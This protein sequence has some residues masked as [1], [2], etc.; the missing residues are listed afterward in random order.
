MAED[1]INTPSHYH[2]GGIDVITIL[3]K[4]FG[5]EAS[6]GF[7]LGN[8]LKYILRYPDKG[9]VSS[10]EKARFYL[11]ALIN[12]VKGKEYVQKTE[13]FKEEAEALPPWHYRNEEINTSMILNHKFGPVHL[14]AFELGNII[15][16]LLKFHGEGELPAYEEHISHLEEAQFHLDMLIQSEKGEEE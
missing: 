4:R 2:K 9:G 6:R 16:L 3:E 8:V 12:N 10:L 5:K 13:G 15:D 14:K 1:L 7:F 11:E